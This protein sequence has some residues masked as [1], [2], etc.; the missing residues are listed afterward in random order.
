M[1]LII[2]KIIRITIGLLLLI[3]L[4]ALISSLEGCCSAPAPSKI[5][6]HDPTGEV[7]VWYTDERVN[8]NNGVVT[9]YERGTNIKMS[10]DANS[11]IV[12]ELPK[13][14]E[15]G[16]VQTNIDPKFKKK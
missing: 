4:V 12:T 8:T 13:P 5:E 14:N 11:V 6:Y 16:E 15:D 1:N 9:F 2:G 7:R 3:G 10:I